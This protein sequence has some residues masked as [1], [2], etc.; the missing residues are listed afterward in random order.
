MSSA[1]VTLRLPLEALDELAALAVEVSTVEALEALAAEAAG[2]RGAE[3]GGV[4]P[5]VGARAALAHGALIA[6]ALDELPE[7]WPAAREGLR[8]HVRLSPRLA[9]VLAEVA[10]AR[11]VTPS[12]LARVWVRVALE[13]RR[14]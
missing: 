2:A 11:G 14:G 1:A 10:K 12:H 4:S 13:A 8:L 9:A 3:V 6:A 7:P 5:A